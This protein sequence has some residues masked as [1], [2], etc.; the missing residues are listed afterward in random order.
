MNGEA[1]G[2]NLEVDSKDEVI[3]YNFFKNPVLVFKVLRLS[4]KPG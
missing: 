2:M 4:L 1:D 3:F